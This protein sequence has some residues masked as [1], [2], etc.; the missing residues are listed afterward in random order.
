MTLTTENP[1]VIW[2]VTGTFLFT[3]LWDLCPNHVTHNFTVIL[4]SGLR[5]LFT[6]DPATFII[7]R[8]KGGY[9]MGLGR[10]IV[11]LDCDIQKVTTLAEVE[12]KGLGNRLNDGKCDPAGRLWAGEFGLK[13]AGRCKCTAE[14]SHQMYFL[15]LTNTFATG[16]SSVLSQRTHTCTEIILKT[17]FQD[18]QNVNSEDVHNVVLRTP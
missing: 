3:K 4:I 6:E 7:P 10:K 13:M 18:V 14:F 12:K 8:E 1:D 5:F 11:A 9:V 2:Y 16:L 15:T 17:R